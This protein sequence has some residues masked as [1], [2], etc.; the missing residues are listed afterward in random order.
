MLWI[1]QSYGWYE[2]L[3]ILWAKASRCYEQ[4]R[5][6]DDM[7]DFRSWDEG[8][9]CYEQLKVLVDMKEFKLCASGSRCYEQLKVVDDMNDLGSHDLRPQNAMN[10]SSL[11]TIWTILGFKPMTLNA[12]NSLGLCMTWMNLGHKL[13]NLDAMNNLGLWMIWTTT[14][15]VRSS[16]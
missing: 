9:R 3:G 7:N 16:F 10:N 15:V 12:K 2:Q 8:S 5:V 6:V 4:L 13:R 1:A 14:K 11:R